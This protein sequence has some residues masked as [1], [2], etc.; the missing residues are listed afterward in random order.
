ML[1]RKIYLIFAILGFVFDIQGQNISLEKAR[2]ITET[3][4]NKTFIAGAKGQNPNS[5]P[6]LELAYIK[7]D[8]LGADT[9]LYYVFNVGNNN[10]FVI[11][12]ADERVRPILAVIEQGSFNVNELNENL[13]FLLQ[14]YTEQI[15]YVKSVGDIIMT[16]DVMATNSKQEI[17]PL[18]KDSWGQ[19]AP[20]NSKCPI[21]NGEATKVG[22]VALAMAQV[23]NYWEYPTKGIGNHSYYWS[24]GGK[25]ITTDF[26]SHQYEWD[27]FYPS[28]G[29][30]SED[31]K[32]A[33]ATL[34]YDCGVS[35]DMDYGINESLSYSTDAITAF[36]KYFGYSLVS[37]VYRDSYN[38]NWDDLLYSELSKGN[39][40][41]YS[42]EK[43]N[44]SGGH[45]FV[46]DGYKDGLFHFNWGW[47]GSNGYFATTALNPQNNNFNY[48]QDII[49]VKP[50][51][52]Y[53]APQKLDRYLYL[54]GSWGKSLY[55]SQE[56][57]KVYVNIEANCSYILE[58][59]S[60][61]V[62]L[63]TTAN[64][65]D[66]KLEIEIDA[67]D[68][69]NRRSAQIWIRNWELNA[70][71]YIYIDQ[72][73]AVLHTISSNY[74]NLPH[75]EQEITTGVKSIGDFT[76]KT[77]EEW[78]NIKD[79]S[80]NS[81][82]WVVSGNSDQSFRSGSINIYFEGAQ[83]RIYIRQ[84]GANGEP[85]HEFVDLGLPSGTKWATLNI[86]A[87]TIKDSGNEFGWTETS[88][89]RQDNGWENRTNATDGLSPDEL[90]QMNIIDDNNNLTPE[91][92]AAHV[93]WGGKWRM[94]TSKEL[95]ELYQQCQWSY[96]SN[97][98]VYELIGPN[99]NV[100]YL[101]LIWSRGYYYG[102]LWTSTA[103]EQG[104]VGCY[105][106]SFSDARGVENRWRGEI[107]PIRPVFDECIVDNQI[108][109]LLIKQ[110]D[111]RC[112][113]TLGQLVEPYSTG[114]GLFKGIL[115]VNG[116]KILVK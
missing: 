34:M 84:D 99:G 111:N 70:N 85:N 14:M 56:K 102:L 11:T 49:S 27:K 26:S 59:S 32:D 17:L 113:N 96:K 74:Y 38:G 95:D 79:I 44:Y 28:Y 58:C 71:K 109:E 3:Y 37:H 89:I 5:I 36:K 23:M 64:Y 53:V 50:H 21:M 78:I 68:T 43:N 93:N 69:E 16:K 60:N 86:G 51:E 46:C 40:L 87:T 106:N 103:T 57:Q 47:N 2:I 100:I 13:Q 116:K 54:D 101:P 91:F 33:I 31:E 7:C 35:V 55:V 48:H 80:T 72:E 66:C 29:Y 73:P 41:I 105:Y 45:C 97:D 112:Y 4:L 9:P 62:N 25:N 110:N 65:G 63:S 115:I 81:V 15:S 22:C 77:D 42:G 10:G 98:N 8:S 88:A 83:K 61:W 82:T 107:L 90:L 39:P 18:L 104:S 1:M 92:D 30:N 67:N 94:P 76:V 6:K 52:N 108:N 19:G 12:S 20:Y 114:N 75:N 24:T